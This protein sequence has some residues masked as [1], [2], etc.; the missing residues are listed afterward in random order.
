MVPFN[1]DTTTTPIIDDVWPGKRHLMSEGYT[2]AVEPHGT[3][4]TNAGE[5]PTEL[6]KNGG[7]N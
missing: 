6:A 3:L 7:R 4:H 1:I 2:V 5:V